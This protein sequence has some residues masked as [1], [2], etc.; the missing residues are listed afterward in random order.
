MRAAVVLVSLMVL[1]GAC[2]DLPTAPAANAD[3]AGPSGVVG[4]PGEGSREDCDPWLDANWCEDSGGGQCM[5]STGAT[6]DSQADAASG[7]TEGGVGGGGGAP[8]PPEEEDRCK[9]GEP[10]LDDPAVQAGLASLWQRSNPLASQDQRLEQG[11]WIIQN[12]DGSYGMAPFHVAVQGPCTINGNLN[13]PAGAVAFVHTHPFA[14]QER[15][16]A[17]GALQTRDPVTGGWRDQIGADGQPIYPNYSN[18]P[19]LPDHELMSDLNST[20]AATGRD[21]LVGVVIDAN[22]ST[23]YTENPGDGYASRRRCAY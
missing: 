3:R 6:G 2:S 17:C 4:S 22:Q 15:Q 21:L 8:P 9:T 14:R 20:L 10:A 19:S 7:C 16:V 1:A 23:V 18:R 5:T 13:P 12:A 11:G